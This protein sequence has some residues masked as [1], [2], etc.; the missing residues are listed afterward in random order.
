MSASCSKLEAAT[1]VVFYPARRTCFGAG[2]E[3]GFGRDW[4]LV[5]ARA[6]AECDCVVNCATKLSK[7]TASR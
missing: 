3:R 5:A 1:E 2:I 7:A 6:D 4:S